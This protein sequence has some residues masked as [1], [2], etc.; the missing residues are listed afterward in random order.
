LDKAERDL[1]LRFL[2][3]GF[4]LMGLRVYE[5][6]LALKYL[7]GLKDAD[8]SRIGVMGHSGGCVVVNL[9]VRLADGIAAQVIL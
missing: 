3:E 5:T 7:R 6:M 2:R 9:L 1:S 8:P 4:T